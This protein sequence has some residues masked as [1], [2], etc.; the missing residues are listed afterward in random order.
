M[1][2]TDEKISGV[3][4]SRHRWQWQISKHKSYYSKKTSEKQLSKAKSLY[5]RFFPQISAAL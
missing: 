3:G 5:A 4:I 1:G 2:H